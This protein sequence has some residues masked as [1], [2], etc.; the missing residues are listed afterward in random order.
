VLIDRSAEIG[1]VDHGFPKPLKLPTETSLQPTPREGSA[2]F[3]PAE[4]G[5]LCPYSTTKA[6]TMRH[7]GSALVLL[8]A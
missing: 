4:K 8:G 2:A 3:R 1:S 7:L 5:R 6:E